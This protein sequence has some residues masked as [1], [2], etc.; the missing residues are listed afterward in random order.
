MDVYI[1]NTIIFDGCF[2]SEDNFGFTLFYKRTEALW[3]SEKYMSLLEKVEM[4]A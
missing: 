4:A 3:I 1:N 2:A